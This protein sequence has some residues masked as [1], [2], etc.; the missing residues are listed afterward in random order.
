LFLPPE[1]CLSKQIQLF[2]WRQQQKAH[3]QLFDFFIV[4]DRILVKERK[5]GSVRI[6]I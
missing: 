5:L 2:F 3:W 4:D 1:D 6:A